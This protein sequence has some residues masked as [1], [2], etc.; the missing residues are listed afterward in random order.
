MHRLI[1]LIPLLF[2]LCLLPSPA[3]PPALDDPEW[4]SGT[5]PNGLRYFI[6]RNTLPEN[7][8]ELRLAVNAGS[9]LEAD[10]QRGLAHFLEH[11][12]F[13]GTENF[14]KNEMVRFL[15]SLG[16][17]FGPDLNAY[18]S[19]D[20]TVYQ[21]RL[22]TEKPEIVE[23]GF[24]ILADWAGRITAA[25]AAIEA[26]RGVIIEEWRGRRG[27]EARVRDQQYPVL[28]P[29]SRYAE[30]MPIGTLE[31][32]QNF[33]FERLRDFYRDWYRPDLM[34]VIAVGDLDVEK[35]RTKI[36][37]LF[38]GFKNPESA[39]KREEFVHP[40]HAETQ[41]GVFSDPELTGSEVVILWKLPPSR[42]RT[43]EA[44][45]T[46]I[47]QSLVADM[48]SQRL[49]EQSQKSDA[50][51]LEAGAYRGGYTRGGD[52][53]LLYAS[54]KDQPGAHLKAAK[55]LLT[56][57]ERARRHGFTQGELERAAARRLSAV[58]QAWRER[59]ST[60]S[61]VFIREGVSHALTGE[62]LPG[63]E[64]NLELHRAVL[65]D[66]S[67]EEVQT[68]FRS[69]IAPENRVI[70]AEG[71]S[72]D[73]KTNLPEKEELLALFAESE[74]LELEP[75]SDGVTDAALVAELPAPGQI[76]ERAEIPELGLHIWKLS[77]GARVMLKP[78]DFKKD[79]IL[80]RAW[81]PGGTNPV[82]LDQLVH[83][84]AADEVMRAGG[85]GAFSAVDLSKKLSGKL[86]GLAPSIRGDQDGFS[87]GASPRD[88]ETLMKLLHLHFTAPRADAEASAAL[89]NRMREGV[90]NRMSDPKV[91]F[92][93]LI[94]QTLSNYHP[95][96]TPPTLE[97]VESLDMDAALE[98]YRE[99][100]ASASDFSFLFVG[101]FT[102]EEIEPLLTQWVASL[103]AG[104]PETP[105]YFPV[106]SPKHEIRRVMRRG[107]EPVAHVRMV[108]TLPEVE[109]SY[110]T[111]H[112]LRSMTSVLQIRL[113][114]VVREEKGGSYH[115][116][117]WPDIQKFPSPR[118]R[119]MVDFGCDP[120]KV[121]MMIAAV[122]GV[123]AA[124]QSELP[125][126]HYI[127]TVQETQRR[128]REVDLRENS[129]W[130]EVLS[131]YDWHNEDPRTILDFERYVE[132]ITPEFVRDWARKAF[133]TPDRAVFILLPAE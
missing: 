20:E 17:G 57:S 41:A 4:T 53:Y 8:L 122:N 14:A 36:E 28:F 54:V 34:S 121:D 110:K 31:V 2:S 81:S 42:A 26:E 78:T 87:G 72:R 61:A 107:V 96:M 111:R 63:R 60:E 56:E 94:E 6:R 19:F 21:L 90:R 80:L 62:Y 105:Q 32:L 113:R 27:A 51:Y 43:A 30:R 37:T 25:D 93:D 5:L 35:T 65:A 22:P 106:G 130:I 126:A 89:R 102:L 133:Q 40:P 97:S 13:N 74:A 11:I 39:P 128:G 101:G 99:R 59:G 88:L 118:A 50:P 84:Q 77:N 48:L 18:T 108:W 103:P 127:Q 10:D 104:K 23:K 75:Y 44:Y 69:W 124:A 100:F 49:Q 76:V 115:V 109:F 125:E 66:L 47:V 38:G 98:F 3:Q 9:I 83:A 117:I 58:E 68:L 120:D 82:A 132:S 33:E 79:E 55:A 85:L 91:E 95:R 24:L 7:R 45:R 12:A 67:L 86:V 46:R 131:F 16:V 73:G 92:G 1:R 70:L 119:I 114:E 29:G 129:F 15:E 123:I 112:A 64:R 116:S 71:P 52:A